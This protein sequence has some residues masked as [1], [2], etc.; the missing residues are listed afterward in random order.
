MAISQY[1]KDVLQ[2]LNRLAINGETATYKAIAIEIGLPETGCHMVKTMTEILTRIYQWHAAR[3]LPKLTALIVKSDKSNPGGIPGNG[4]WQLDGN[5]HLSTREKRA[6]TD[7]YQREVWDYYGT[8]N[9]YGHS[10]DC[11]LEHI[12][13]VEFDW[14][15][16]VDESPVVDDF[17]CTLTFPGGTLVRR[18]AISGNKR[19]KMNTALMIMLRRLRYM[20]YNASSNEGNDVDVNVD[21]LRELLDIGIAK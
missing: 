4:F 8:V 5:D 6:L 19:E 1:T 11:I 17:K 18:F 9:G 13:R 20:V 14:V 16:V 2:I 15:P 3:N 10:L 7:V 21:T 12:T